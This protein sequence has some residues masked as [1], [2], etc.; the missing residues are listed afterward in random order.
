[1]NYHKKLRSQLHNTMPVFNATTLT[2]TAAALAITN[3]YA[4]PYPN[5]GNETEMA[6]ALPT[7]SFGGCL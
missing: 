3:R 4:Y 6:E 2:S 5:L 1:M 7:L